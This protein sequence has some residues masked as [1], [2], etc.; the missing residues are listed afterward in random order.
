MVTTARTSE[1]IE[2]C[3]GIKT[4]ALIGCVASTSASKATK[5][6]GTTR[7]AVSGEVKLIVS[8]GGNRPRGPAGLPV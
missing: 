2:T 4:E 3:S 6:G 1:I 5:Y 8:C 7:A